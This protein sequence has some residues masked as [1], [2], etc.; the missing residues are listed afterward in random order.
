[1]IY[2][3][4]I[5]HCLQINLKHLENEIQEKQT[6]ILREKGWEKLT[7]LSD[8]WDNIKWFYMGIT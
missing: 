1:M 6:E 8:L 2:L 7:R 3:K 5:I 4:K